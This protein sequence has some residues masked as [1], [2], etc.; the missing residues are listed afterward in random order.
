MSGPRTDAAPRYTAVDK[1]GEAIDS[2]V[3]CRAG[4]PK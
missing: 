2:D 4:G 3:Y 1:G